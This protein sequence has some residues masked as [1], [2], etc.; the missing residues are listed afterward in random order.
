[1]KRA[2]SG[3]RPAAWVASAAVLYIAVY[4]VTAWVSHNPLR[5]LYDSTGDVPVPYQWVRPPPDLSV[6][7][8]AP[9]PEHARV[10]PAKGGTFSTPDAQVVLTIPAGALPTLFPGEALSIDIQPLMPTSSAPLETG[11]MADGNVY[12]V[13]FTGV[14]DAPVSPI[15][16]TTVPFDI[17][18]REPEFDLVDDALFTSSGPA[19]PW[20]RLAAVQSGPDALVAQTQSPGYY[21]LAGRIK[22]SRVSATRVAEVAGAGIGVVILLVVA[23]RRGRRMVDPAGRS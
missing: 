7:N 13:R 9:A 16:T 20:R 17:A 18:L 8:V 12:L 23:I 21:V 10:D 19:G 6:D 15:A 2:R 22:T 14:G 3:V 5:L 11:R 1:M 4:V